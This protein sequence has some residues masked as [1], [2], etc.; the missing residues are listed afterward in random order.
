[1]S[2]HSRLPPDSS[3]AAE[4]SPQAVTTVPSVIVTLTAREEPAPASFVSHIFLPVSMSNTASRS[5]A[6]VSGS[7]SGP[8]SPVPSSPRPSSSPA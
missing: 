7:A 5:Q 4:P 2:A 3:Y 8:P 6:R 1:M